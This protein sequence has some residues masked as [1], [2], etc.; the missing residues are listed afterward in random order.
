MPVGPKYS[1]GRPALRVNVFLLPGIETRF[2]GRP[3]HFLLQL[4]GLIYF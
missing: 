1:Y 4:L 3:V 2:V